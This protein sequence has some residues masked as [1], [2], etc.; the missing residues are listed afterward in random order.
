MYNRKPSYAL[1]I[2]KVHLCQDLEH[3][4]NIKE[5]TSTIPFHK[6]PTWCFWIY[7]QIKLTLY[8][9][10][11]SSSC[12]PASRRHRHLQCNQIIQW[13]PSISGRLL[14]ALAMIEYCYSIQRI[15]LTIIKHTSN[16]YRILYCNCSDK[17]FW[18][19]CCASKKGW[20]E[21]QLN[22]ECPAASWLD[23]IVNS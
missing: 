14:I 9:C 22:P 18:A 5:M 8:L 7:S 4:C 15:M 12:W 2:N 1:G 21:L 10:E 11:Q 3:V 13:S 23:P 20:S 19:A 17:A 6:N 16:D